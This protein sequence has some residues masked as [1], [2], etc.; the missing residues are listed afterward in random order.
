MDLLASRRAKDLDS[1][2]EQVI[3][4]LI[5]TAWQKGLA[6]RYSP[7]KLR[8]SSHIDALLTSV[9][10]PSRRDPLASALA[11]SSARHELK[12][13]FVE[14]NTASSSQIPLSSSG[15][16]PSPSSRSPEP[17]EEWGLKPVKS[18]YKC[19]I[20]IAAPPPIPE[21]TPQQKGSKEKS[22]PIEPDHLIRAN[23]LAGYWELNRRFIRQLGITNQGQVNPNNARMSGEDGPISNLAQISP[24][25]AIGES[26]RV[27]EKTSIKKC[28]IGRHCV[29]GKGAKLTGCVLWDFVV[30]EEKY[31]LFIFSISCLFALT[32]QCEDREHHPVF[33]REDWSQSTDQGL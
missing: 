6:Q 26:T 7:S 20:V 19:Q 5:K 11:R 16:L 17:R 14:D 28:V 9:L 22:K 25:S 30:I 12:G 3:P 18:G 33:Q 1:L 4:W 10:D 31:V 23:S 8:L 15:F 21:P 24:D 32:A 29:I 13:T 2:R 27:A